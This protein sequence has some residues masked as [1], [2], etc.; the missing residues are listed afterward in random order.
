[1]Q[2]TC[3]WMRSVEVGR[4]PTPV[5][6]TTLRSRRSALTTLA[7]LSPPLSRSAQ[8]FSQRLNQFSLLHIFL[9][10]FSAFTVF[11][12]RQEEHLVC[13]N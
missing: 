10:A 7:R 13:K 6:P 4:F 12:G 8:L 3:C 2:L 5:R 9:F 1:M 11:V